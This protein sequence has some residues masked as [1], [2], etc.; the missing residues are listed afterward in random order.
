M[1]ETSRPTTMPGNPRAREIKHSATVFHP[2]SA[3]NPA[4]S[5]GEL[6]LPLASIGRFHPA[7]M[8]F[9]SSYPR[10]AGGEAAAK[11]LSRP[12]GQR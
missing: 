8:L 3:T 7:E 5:S 1:I 6:R 11:P 9:E 12:E 10:G 2:R 4:S